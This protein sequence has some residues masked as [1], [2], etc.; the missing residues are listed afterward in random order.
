MKY[1]YIGVFLCLILTYFHPSQMIFIGGVS[2]SVALVL[3]G[4][5]KEKRRVS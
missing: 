4:L 3:Y 1:I 5:W 2:L